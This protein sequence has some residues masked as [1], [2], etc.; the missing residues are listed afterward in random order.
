MWGSR[1]ISV[2][3]MESENYCKRGNVVAGKDKQ[4]SWGIAVYRKGDKMPVESGALSMYAFMAGSTTD[5]LGMKHRLRW[6]T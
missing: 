4:F 1:H 2:D 3:Q 6:R 5:L